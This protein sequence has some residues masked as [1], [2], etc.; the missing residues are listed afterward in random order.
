M[1]RVNLVG[2]NL[3]TGSFEL[4][5]PISATKYSGY[6]EPEAREQ[7]SGLP[8]GFDHLYS[9]DILVQQQLS[10]FSD[11]VT[12][13]YRLIGIGAPYGATEEREFFVR[14]LPPPQAEGGRLEIEGGSS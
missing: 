7:I 3:R 13:T 6:M 10:N 14:P 11:E 12:K 5:D 8:T 1:E 2:V 9:A 4:Y